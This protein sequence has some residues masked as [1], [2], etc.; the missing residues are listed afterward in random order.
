MIFWKPGDK[1]EWRVRPESSFCHF[2]TFV[3][4]IEMEEVTFKGRRWTWANN[5]VW[6]GYI[7]EWLDLFFGSD[8]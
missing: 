8:E 3:R 1:R 4:V 6:E 2:R 7:E 5:R